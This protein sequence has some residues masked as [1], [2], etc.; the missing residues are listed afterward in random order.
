MTETVS[1]STERQAWSGRRRSLKHTLYP[2]AL[3][4]LAEQGY[5]SMN[6]YLST[7]NAVSLPSYSSLKA[8]NLLRSTFRILARS[9]ML[10][11]KARNRAQT[12]LQKI[13]NITS[14]DVDYF[15]LTYTHATLFSQWNYPDFSCDKLPE[16]R[17][18]SN[19][20]L[21][22]LSSGE[23]WGTARMKTGLHVYVLLLNNNVREIVYF[24]NI[25]HWD[26]TADINVFAVKN[27]FW[28]VSVSSLI[29][30]T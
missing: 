5:R 19:R 28:I 6:L 16:V 18:R 3:S 20:T 17:T 4:S 22:L 1:V 9:P 10:L 27:R 8:E 29:G 26:I 2:R 25:W 13:N 15:T 14:S 23:T 21:V 12:S 30:Y 11:S 7:S 24:L